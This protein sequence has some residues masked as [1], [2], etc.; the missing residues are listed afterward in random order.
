MKSKL[1]MLLVLCV[2]IAHGQD[3]TVVTG[4]DPVSFLTQLWDTIKSWLAVGLP[5]A[6]A[7]YEL[8]VRI[9]PTASN[10]SIFRL[11][12]WLADLIVAN[13]SKQGTFKAYEDVESEK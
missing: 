6:I 9:V 3:T 4:G 5:I 10:W 2:V 8:L 12:E 11:L 13:K 1:T 7:A